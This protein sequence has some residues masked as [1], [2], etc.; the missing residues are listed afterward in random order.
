MASVWGRVLGQK[1]VQELPAAPFGEAGKRHGHHH[2]QHGVGGAGELPGRAVA[3]ANDHPLGA[4]HHAAALQP[5]AHEGGETG[6]D[7]HEP[8]FPLN[9]EEPM[10][11]DVEEGDGPHDARHVEVGAG[12]R[13]AQKPPRHAVAAEEVRVDVGRGHL[14]QQNARDEHHNQ[15]GGDDRQ[16]EAADGDHLLTQRIH[17]IGPLVATRCMLHARR[18][19]YALVSK[20][21]RVMESEIPRRIQDSPEAMRVVDPLRTGRAARAGGGADRIANRP[22][23]TSSKL[24]R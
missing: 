3:E 2:G 21:T 16:I 7:R 9:P 10:A 24:R 6:H 23:K 5:L 17:A 20:G 4:G 13:N 15:I 11:H 8:P 12:A 22:G 14:R 18:I 19:Y 1:D